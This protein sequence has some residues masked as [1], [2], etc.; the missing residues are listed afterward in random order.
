MSTL[1]AEVIPNLA[2]RRLAVEGPLLP[3][4]NAVLLGSI[5]VAAELRL[6]DVP[7]DVAEEIV[8]KMPLEATST[9]PVRR[10][11][12][13]QRRG[14]AFAYHPP[15]GQAILSGCCRDP[16]P[17]T[18]NHSTSSL[19]EQ[20]VG[21]CDDD[22]EAT[23][24]MLRAIRSPDRALWGTPHEPVV[25]SNLWVQG[26]GLGAAGRD[27][28]CL[29][30]AQAIVRGTEEVQAS[31]RYV[32]MKLDGLY[33]DRHVRR[34]LSALDTHGLITLRR[35]RTGL[36]RVETVSSEDLVKLEEHLGVAGRRSQNVKEARLGSDA[37]ADWLAE[38]F[39]RHNDLSAALAAWDPYGSVR[40]DMSQ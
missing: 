37:H 5:A 36:R 32:T 16:R 38:D 7:Q 8:L 12:K 20:F 17:R 39:K 3:G 25:R 13:Q 40:T 27:V 6:Q 21:Y 19:R 31:S 15:D 10:L 26:G 24:P 35:K 33:S 1:T 22:C 30:A 2:K 9:N 11:R 28:Y 18:G 14:V 4:T 29:V 34:M 23:C